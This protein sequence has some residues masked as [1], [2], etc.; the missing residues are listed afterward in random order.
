MPEEA[1]LT[2]PQSMTPDRDL[3]T[4]PHMAL[5][6][7]LFMFGMF[8]SLGVAVYMLMP[9][10]PTNPRIMNYKQIDQ[11]MG[12]LTD[13]EGNPASRQFRKHLLKD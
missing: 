9:A 4:D 1:E 7:L 10:K 5:R 11:D 8:S 6:H 3:H 12:N 13:F 2:D